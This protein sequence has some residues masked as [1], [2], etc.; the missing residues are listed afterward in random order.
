MLL[1]IFLLYK[2]YLIDIFMVHKLLLLKHNIIIKIGISDMEIGEERDMHD[3]IVEEVK[4]PTICY[5]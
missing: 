1:H 5:Y 3:I 2:S 4:V